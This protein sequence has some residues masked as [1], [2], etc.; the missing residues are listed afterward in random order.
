MEILDGRKISQ[1]L[2]EA[3]RPRVQKLIKE[4]NIEPKLVF[5]LIGES[6]ASIAYVGMKEKA[7]EKIGII[8]EVLR[9]TNE[10]SQDEI[11]SKIDELNQD[12]DVHGMMIQLPLPNHLDVSTLTSSILPQKDA[13]G[14]HPVNVGN[15]FLSV[16]R[17]ELPPATA[18]G[19]VRLIEAY[20]INLRGLNVTVIGRSNL[21]GKPLAVMLINRDATV[22]VC[23]SK[24]KDI[25]ACCR[26]AD[27]IISATGSPKLVQ[28]DWVSE[29]AIV[30]DAG[31]A[32]VDGK[33]CGD[34]DF[35]QVAEK[36]S[37]ITPVPGGVGPMTIYSIVEN[38]VRAAEKPTEELKNQ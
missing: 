32:V 2:F 14:L 19:I 24:S 31:Y 5:F 23:H 16:E 4:K 8:S 28:A 36:C 27:M 11:L 37:Y 1:T 33:T 7:C 6:P 12:D 21:V 10:V 30:I 15:M 22:T 13:D 3:L 9:Y 18:L 26:N 34:V 29:G 38:T 25:A 17:E 35:D 20:D